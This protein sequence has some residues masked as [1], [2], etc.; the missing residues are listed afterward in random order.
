LDDYAIVDDCG[1]TM[2]IMPDMF[3][4]LMGYNALGIFVITVKGSSAGCATTCNDLQR[5][6]IAIG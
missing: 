1:S 6:S 4:G 3:G 5:Q 2:P